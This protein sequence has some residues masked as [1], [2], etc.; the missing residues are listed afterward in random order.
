MTLDGL[1]AQVT[2][3]RA[4]GPRLVLLRGSLNPWQLWELERYLRERAISDEQVVLAFAPDDIAVDS[5]PIPTPAELVA[6]VQRAARARST[7]DGV[8]ELR[9]KYLIVKRE[10]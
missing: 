6:D 1:L 3:A 5:L 4:I 7:Q 2:E 9:R 10:A 8:A